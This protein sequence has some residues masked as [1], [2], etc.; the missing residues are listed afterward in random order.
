MKLQDCF[1]M[2]RIKNVFLP[3]SSSQEQRRFR[4]I[5]NYED[6]GYGSVHGHCVASAAQP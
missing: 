1:Q 6:E 3:A 5:Q 4:E 2:I